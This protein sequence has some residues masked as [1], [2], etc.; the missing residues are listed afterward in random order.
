MAIRCEDV[1]A[2]LL[3]LL[4]GELPEGERAPLQAHVDS[5]ARCK[6][7]LSG[8]QQT[9]A[10]ARQVLDEPVPARA[11]AAILQAAAAQAAAAKPAKRATEAQ[12]SFWDRLRARWALPTLATVGAIAVFL[13]ASKLL[14]EPDKAYQRGKEALQPM[15]ATAPPVTNEAQPEPKPEPKPI[16]S[17]LA[18]R[19]DEAKRKVGQSQDVAEPAADAE[20]DTGDRALRHATIDQG[21]GNGKAGKKAAKTPA[22]A[23]NAKREEPSGG[24]AGGGLGRLG[25]GKGAGLGSVGSSGGASDGA[26]IE[27]LMNDASPSQ[28]RQYAAPPPARAPTAQPKAKGDVAAEPGFAAPPPAAAPRPAPGKREISDSPFEGL[29]SVTPTS[30]HRGEAAAKEM[31]QEEEAEAPVERRPVAKKKSAPADDKVPEKKASPPVVVSAP[32]ASVQSAPAGAA[33]KP[34]A[35]PLVQRAD[36]LFAQGQWAAAA[37]LYRQ[38]IN[39]DPRNPDAARWRQRLVVAERQNEAVEA[40]KAAKAAPASASPPR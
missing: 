6:A 15:P 14:L 34:A 38:L 7:E 8:F 24:A 12:P 22:V 23:A 37:T 20:K 17:D 19:R 26:A 11:R 25:A 18:K 40:A 31:A 32:A 35:D 21:F 13:L 28:R 10:V 29:D 3:E 16:D 9:R 36:Q 27:D 5:C 4:Y 2:R 39:R 1:T 33:A 30:R